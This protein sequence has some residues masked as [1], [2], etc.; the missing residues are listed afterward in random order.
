MCFLVF[1]V[2]YNP[3]SCLH[4][5]HTTIFMNTRVPK[6]EEYGIKFINPEVVI[7]K[8]GVKEGMKIAD[9]GCGTGYFSLAFGKKVGEEGKVYALD[10]LPQ[11]LESVESQAKSLGI[12]NITTHRVNLEKENGSKLESNDIDW[13]VMKD[14]LFQNKNKD[15]IIAEARRVLKEGGKILIIEWNLEDTSIGPEKEL[16]ISREALNMLA[17]REKLCFS[18]EIEVGNFH[19]GLIFTK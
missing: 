18:K 11:K 5:I 12:S 7:E 3:D 2:K 10:I 14:M 9:F 13:V 1:I 17:D 6:S 15:K 8:L 4:K 16:R 19:Y